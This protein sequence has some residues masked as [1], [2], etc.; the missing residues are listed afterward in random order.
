LILP[1]NPG[2]PERPTHWANRAY[3]QAVKKGMYMYI[4]GG[5]DYNLVEVP[6]PDWPDCPPLP[7]GAPPIPCLPSIQVPFSNFFNDVWRSADGISWENLTQGIGEN[8]IWSGRAGL[9]AVVLDGYIYVMGGS[10]NDDCS[11]IPGGCPP[12]APPPRKYF[13]DVWR[14]KDGKKWEKVLDEAPWK[15]RAGGIAVVKDGYIYMIGGEE[16]FTCDDPTRPCPP[17]FNDVWRSKN[18]KDWELMTS[19]AEWSKRPGHQVVVA[20]NRLVLF[21]GFGLGEDNG[22]TP[23]NPR[24]IW[25]SNKGKVWKK[26]SDSPWNADDSEQ[27]KYDF[28]AVVTHG[29]NGEGDAIY[30]FGGD[31]ETFDFNDE[32]NFLRMDNDVWR[33][34]FTK[35]KEDFS[36][37]QHVTQVESIRD[38]NYPNPFLHSTTIRYQL[39]EKGLVNVRIYDRH[40]KFIRNLSIGKLVAGNHECVWDGNKHDGKPAKPGLYYARI[41]KNKKVNTLKI[42]KQ[43]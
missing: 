6:N 34:T 33:F 23:S 18:G 35:D 19:D 24:D 38:Y 41:I 36:S 3:F 9:S 11:I 7:P 29:K 42:F 27:I 30:T 17:Y 20:Q 13:N 16:G 37:D 8:E 26:V 43:G 21:G 25:I 14:S 39:K 1:T 32:T 31:R 40:G 12:G 28:D 22:V 15:K 10:Q 2:F 4:M 5:Q